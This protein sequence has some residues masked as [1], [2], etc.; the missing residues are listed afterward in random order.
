MRERKQGDSYTDAIMLTPR[1]QNLVNIIVCAGGS[2][3]WCVLEA[4]YDQP[5]AEFTDTESAEQYALRIADSKSAWK[6]DVY[7]TKW[8]L[9][10][11][12]NSEDDATP[13]PNLD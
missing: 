13:K 6:V 2:G 5:L 1:Q 11:A 12:Y 9:I 10:A 7:D 8:H 3:K 4:G